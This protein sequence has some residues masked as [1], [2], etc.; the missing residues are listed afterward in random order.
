[1]ITADEYLMILGTSPPDDFDALIAQ[2]D[3]EINRATLYGLIGRDTSSFPSFVLDELKLAYAYQVQYLSE[4]AEILNETG[5]QSF[6][7]GKF[8]LSAATGSSEGDSTQKLS[9]MARNSL[10]TVT[11][12]LRGL[13]T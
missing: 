10:I 3:T 1:M 9:P 7:L 11:A 13:R 5:T 6:T 12:Y 2:A 8:S 4:N